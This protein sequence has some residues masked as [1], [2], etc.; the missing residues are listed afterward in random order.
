MTSDSRIPIQQ[1]GRLRQR[2]AA[3][4]ND[5]AAAERNRRGIDEAVASRRKT[6][7]RLEAQLAMIECGS[8]RVHDE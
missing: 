4:R 5:I 8:A 7:Q 1:A 6:L 3:L 2:I